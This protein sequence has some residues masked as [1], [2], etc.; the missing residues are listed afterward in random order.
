MRR[1]GIG[2]LLLLGLCACHGR[3]PAADGWFDGARRDHGATQFAEDIG[4]SYGVKL[5]PY[6]CRRVAA[7][8]APLLEG[9][10]ELGP[11][12]PQ[13]PLNCALPLALPGAPQV[14]VQLMPCFVFERAAA[15]LGAD[16]S[17]RIDG[18]RALHLDAVSV[19]VAIG[20]RMALS[21]S[22]A[23]VAAAAGDTYAE[24]ELQALAARLAQALLPML[25]QADGSLGPALG[26]D[27]QRQP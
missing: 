22:M 20:E 1:P 4:M 6:W 15:E 14:L 5:P 12:A 19:G 25:R 7:V 11:L 21:V 24:A 9:V 2:C 23:E 16:A 13:D 27:A 3:D 18:H 26:D 17:L 8:A 10:A